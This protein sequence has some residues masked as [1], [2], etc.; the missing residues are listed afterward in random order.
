MLILDET[1]DYLIKKII[2]DVSDGVPVKCTEFVRVWVATSDE[3]ILQRDV[4]ESK[5]NQKSKGGKKKKGKVK[6]NEE[7]KGGSS[8]VRVINVSGE[9]FFTEPNL[10]THRLAK[11]D[12][13]IC[14]G[15]VL[16]SVRNLMTRSQKNEMNPLVINIKKIVKL[17]VE[18]LEKQ[19]YVWENSRTIQATIF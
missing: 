13:E 19:G 14:A 18:I 4:S 3:H 2:Q 10:S 12:R 5:E 9:V 15:Y 7:K 8:G 1:H 17:P 16:L 6:E 11:S